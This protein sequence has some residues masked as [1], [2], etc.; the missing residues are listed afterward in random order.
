MLYLLG[1]Y[2]LVLGQDEKGLREDGKKGGQQ[3]MDEPEYV[4]HERCLRVLFYGAL[5]KLTLLDSSK[6]IKPPRAAP[7]RRSAR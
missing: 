7:S 5:N 2:N 3:D 4:A 6:A 1:R